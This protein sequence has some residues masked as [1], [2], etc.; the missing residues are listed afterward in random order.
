MT[1]ERWQQI[2]H[3][4]GA[5]MEHVDLAERSRFIHQACNGDTKLRREVE[6][7]LATNSERFDQAAEELHVSRDVSSI[8]RRIGAYVLVRELGRGGMGAVFLAERA[9]R[10]FTKQVAIKLLKRGTDTDEVLRRFRAERE[11]LARLEHPNI[12]RLF[13]GGTTD[14]GLPYFV[15]EYVAGTPITE[16]CVE[17]KLSIE[18]RL[19]LFLKVCD[20][21]RFAH[22]NLI[23][24]RDLKPANIL[25]TPDG[26]P[27]LLDF[28]IAKLVEADEH[29]AFVTAFDRQRLTPA[30]ASPEQVRGEPV[31]TV[32][33]VYSLGAL[34]YEILS[35]ETA[36]RFS[37]LNP[38]PT[39]LWRV[40]VQEEPLRPSM[41][42]RS[43][44]SISKPLRGDL[45]NIILKA[46]RKEPTRRYGGIGA[47][48]EDIRR[49][50]TNRP[51][52]ARKDTL[53]YRTGKLFKRNKLAV[54][55]GLSI[56]LTLIAGI[57]A[58]A[59]QAR[60]AQRERAKAERRFDDI[61]NIADSLLFELHDSIKDIP[62]AMAAR[63]LVTQRS[64]EY[65]DN[66]ARDAADDPS[67]TSELATAYQK[68]GEITF[69][70]RAAIDLHRKAAALN[71]TL[72]H[73]H[74]GNADYER[75]LA[76]N[77]NDLSDVMKISGHSPEALDYARKSVAV[78]QSLAREKPG[79]DEIK[80]ALAEREMTLGIAAV[81]AGDFK[82]AVDVDLAALSLQEQVFARRPN[83]IEAKRS[84]GN[85]H[86]NLSTAYESAG[87]LR[88]AREHAQKSFEISSEIY[89]VDPANARYRRD[90]WSAHYRLARQ[91]AGEGDAGAAREHF[92]RAL[93][94]I[95]SLAAAD[96]ND[97]GHRRWIAVTR[98]SLGEFFAAQNQFDAARTEYEKAIATAEPLARDDADRIE[99]QRDLARMHQAM[100]RMFAKTGQKRR[101][102]ES[103][104][105]ARALA[106]EVAKRDPQNK[107][108]S[109]RLAEID[110]DIASCR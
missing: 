24:H 109:E 1:S 90:M 86:G 107:R 76:E 78:M 63:Q 81:D 77:Y 6:S 87:D 17:K 83:D 31:T 36:H 110:S 88:A 105:K 55:A 14:D 10:E 85:G 26:E 32:S 43:T 82:T 95:E 21:V 15:M 68:I 40:V 49:Y 13:D 8:G 65:L 51:V 33:D 108:V 9:D 29:S 80:A 25:V 66:L 58:T 37:N 74:P 7:L 53:V 38:P 46:L 84:V 91:F 102:L 60:V 50:L 23:V 59:H 101:A 64:V 100:G 41:A 72:V 22:Q 106:E 30:Y 52:H 93:E 12:A 75:R 92:D 28:G 57:I 3:V 103:L 99:T 89:G 27:K 69:D 94:F 35:G 5:A 71:E 20:A 96:P 18:Q 16:F 54:A 98:L 34:L 73:A 62:G 42:A 2:K 70:V 44:S 104:R 67:L 48:A 79:D 61:R 56:L 45:D 11:I 97:R 19:Q 47:F 39:E 4:I